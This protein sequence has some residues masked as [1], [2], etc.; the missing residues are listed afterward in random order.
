MEIDIELDE[1]QKSTLENDMI[2][3]SAKKISLYQY[4]NGSFFK[5]PLTDETWRGL[6]KT[7]SDSLLK[8]TVAFIIHG[9]PQI[10]KE[11][12]Y[13]LSKC[14]PGPYKSDLRLSWKLTT[15]QIKYLN[16]DKKLLT[17]KQLDTWAE[18]WCKKGD[19]PKKAVFDCIYTIDHFIHNIINF[20]GYCTFTELEIV[21]CFRG[22]KYII[23]NWEYDMW[24]ACSHT[25]VNRS[26]TRISLHSTAPLHCNP[27]MQTI[28]AVYLSPSTKKIK[29]SKMKIQNL[30]FTGSGCLPESFLLEDVE[31]SFVAIQTTSSHYY[32]LNPSLLKSKSLEV[33]MDTPNFPN[34]VWLLHHHPHPPPLCICK[35]LPQKS[36]PEPKP[37][38]PQLPSSESE[39]GSPQQPEPGSLGSQCLLC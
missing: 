34:G 4:S 1:I 36:E 17:I 28:S 7:K 30:I 11:N 18:D 3:V 24:L 6:V 37:G 19:V 31:V 38:F 23:P 29:I 39:P 14:L 22:A 25:V 32:Q 33:N 10:L 8:L 20:H 12:A 9:D 5:R 13:K 26:K 15:L 21:G 35:K 16:Q 2:S 27:N